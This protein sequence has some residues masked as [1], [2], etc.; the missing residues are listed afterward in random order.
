MLSWLKGS[1]GCGGWGHPPL[2][3]GA[4]YYPYRPKRNVFLSVG[5]STDRNEKGGKRGWSL[6]LAWLKG[7]TGCA[8]WGTPAGRE[9]LLFLPAN[10]ILMLVPDKA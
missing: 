4:G 10:T 7:S 6:M 9:V 1:T 3:R 8:E 5:V 2:E